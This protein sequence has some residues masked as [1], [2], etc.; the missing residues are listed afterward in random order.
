MIFS[1][2]GTLLAT[3][4]KVHLFDMH[5]PGKIT[6]FESHALSPGSTPTLVDTAFGKVG[7]AICHD[8]RF[9]ELAMIAARRGA[10]LMVYPAAFNM[11]T[12]PLHFEMLARARAVDNQIYVAMC[13]PA[14]NTLGEGYVAWA[15]S[16]IVD[17]NA[18]V[19]AGLK[20]E[21]GRIECWLEPARI[22]EVRGAIPVTRQRRFDVYPDVTEIVVVGGDTA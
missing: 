13:A 8:L 10:F 9:P 4:R 19:L 2:T 20:E 14:R 18:E 15:H 12:G 1:P 7:V 3:H 16:C 11:T 22:E 21:E 5:I 6:F 17:P